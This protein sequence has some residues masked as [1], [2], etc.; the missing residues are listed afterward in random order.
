MGRRPWTVHCMISCS[1]ADLRL[2]R[3]SSSPVTTPL[4]H[5]GSRWPRKV[6]LSQ[7]PGTIA[8]MPLIER[9]R[10]GQVVVGSFVHE[11]GD[12]AAATEW[13][14]SSCVAFTD[15][16]S[17]QIRSRRGGGAVTPGRVLVGAAGAEHECRHPVG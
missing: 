12:A 8:L 1:L 4:A 14:Q 6:C 3:P 10:T 9:I 11:P 13:W 5:S 15:F 16:G 2:A 17:W 7:P